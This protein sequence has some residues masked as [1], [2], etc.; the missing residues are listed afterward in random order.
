MRGLPAMAAATKEANRRLVMDRWDW[1]E[2]EVATILAYCQ[3]DVVLTTRLLEWM[4]PAIDYPRALL[5]G[6][7]MTAV[8]RMERAGIPI[9][10]NLHGHLAACWE[11]LKA[12]LI[13]E[14]DA[15]FCVYEGTTFKSDRFAALLAQSRMDW[16]R[17]PSG[18]LILDDDTFREQSRRY[19]HLYP[20][21]QLRATLSGLRLTGLSIGRDGRNRCLLSPF[22]SVTGRNQPTRSTFGP[23]K[24]MRHLIKPPE[25]Y[26]VAYIDWTSQ[27][28]GIAAGL[29]GDERMIAGYC[30]GDPYMAFARIAGLPLLKRPRPLTG[31]SESA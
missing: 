24:W 13:E 15:D 17:Y 30:A 16:P 3:D 21:R 23:A 11:P 7:Y 6:R 9:D 22:A 10:T 12:R 26:G 1:S 20:L 31:L 14:V 5:R 4:A 25:G 18:R 29:S 19:S 27:E 8:A 2:Q 28:L